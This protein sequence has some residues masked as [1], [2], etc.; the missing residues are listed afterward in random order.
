R[1][2]SVDQPILQADPDLWTMAYEATPLMVGGVLYTSTSLSQVAAINAA[3][4]KTLWVY[5]PKAYQ[6]GSPPN[7]GFVHRGVAYWQDGADQRILITT[8][9]GQECI[10]G[11]SVSQSAARTAA[12]PDKIVCLA[13]EGFLTV[14]SH[15]CRPRSTRRFDT[16]ARRCHGTSRPAPWPSR[17]ATP[18]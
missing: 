18:V 17:I 10:L 15:R 11:A 9:V 1:W 14:C 4:G 5:D 6:H 16:P 3:T 12:D 8:T 7:R 13:H 2:L